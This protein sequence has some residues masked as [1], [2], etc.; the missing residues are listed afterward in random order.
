MKI[1]VMKNIMRYEKKCQSFVVDVVIKFTNIKTIRDFLELSL[2]RK[3]STNNSQSRHIFEFLQSKTW[4]TTKELNVLMN[5]SNLIF[6][7]IVFVKERR[8]ALNHL[9]T[10]S[11]NKYHREKDFIWIE[12]FDV[13]LHDFI[14]CWILKKHNSFDSKDLS[15][16]KDTMQTQLTK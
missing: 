2:L 6:A 9:M 5:I 4:C 1:L 12:K 3:C 13:C 11:K 14:T 7:L 10:N 15:K 16:K 8:R